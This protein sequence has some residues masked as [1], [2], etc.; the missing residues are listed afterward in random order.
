[1]S[2]KKVIRSIFVQ[3]K[4]YFKDI[5]NRTILTRKFLYESSDSELKALIYLFHLIAKKEIEISTELYRELKRKRKVAQ[6]Q[7]LSETGSFNELLSESRKAH[8]EYLSKLLNVI[9]P[10]VECL[11]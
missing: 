3:N 9:V 5:L 2:D 11:K 4:Q 1:M 8:L 6:I 7:K 10:T